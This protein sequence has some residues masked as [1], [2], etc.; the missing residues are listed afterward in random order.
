VA[1][2]HKRSFVTKLRH[3]WGRRHCR[4]DR[5]LEFAPRYDSRIVEAIAAL[6]DS[7]R[8]IAE[9]CRRV[10]VVAARLGLPKPSYVHVRRFVVLERARRE[11]E[12]LRR[13]ALRELAEEVATDVLVGRFVHAY[14]VAG[15]VADIRDRHG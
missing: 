5:V 9:T 4:L 12:R 14:D 7:R 15:R 8:P 13:E 11:A 10:G 1:L 3:L 6:D 2:S